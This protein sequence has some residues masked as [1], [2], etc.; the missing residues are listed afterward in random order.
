M[1]TSAPAPPAEWK[2][3]LEHKLRRKLELHLVY[4]HFLLVLANAEEHSNAKGERGRA[5]R[6]W[7]EYLK[8]LIVIC[9]AQHVLDGFRREEK[10]RAG[11][12][13]ARRVPRY[14][15]S[16]SPLL[17]RFKLNWKL[18]SVLAAIE[19][20]FEANQRTQVPNSTCHYYH[21]VRIRPGGIPLPDGAGGLCVT[22]RS[23]R[24]SI[25]ASV[26]GDTGS[27]PA[28][29]ARR[30]ASSPSTSPPLNA[31]RTRRRTSRGPRP[32]LF[33]SA[34]LACARSPAQPFSSPSLSL[35]DEWALLVSFIF[36]AVPES[37][38]SSSS[39]AARLR[40]AFPSRKLLFSAF[41]SRRS[42]SRSPQPKPELPPPLA[43]V[44]IASFQAPSSRSELVVEFRAEVRKSPSLLSLSLSLS[45]AQPASPTP[46]MDDD[47]QGDPVWVCFSDDEDVSGPASP[48][49]DV[50]GNPDG[51]A[52][53]GDKVYEDEKDDEE[54]PKVEM[55]TSITE[56]GAFPLLLEDVLE[57]LG[58][59]TRPL[60]I[61]TYMTSISHQF[62][63]ELSRTEYC[64]LPRR[65]PGTEQTVVVGGG[66]TADP[67]LNVL[68]RVTAALNTDLEGVINEL[69]QA[70][71]RIA[72]LEEQLAEQQGQ[73][74]DDERMANAWSPPRK[75]LRYGAPFSVT[76]FRE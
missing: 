28:A 21:P 47:V 36:L 66:P 64:H 10:R 12:T 11:E 20:V 48:T 74:D 14:F 57:A 56:L 54:E 59:Y 37:N 23:A 53:E 25:A 9:R 19:N 38:S 75:K 73:G 7:I 45:R 3:G 67:R 35:A 68:A 62:Q 49:A 70:Q 13:T 52:D 26:A 31:R 5:A 18:I 2:D 50:E 76:Q 46:Q 58:N 30:Y 55:I 71:D 51:T 42:S 72:E 40:V 1:A 39:N 32:N 33:S 6:L 34:Q 65:R 61:T 43:R 44:A 24:S 4:L 16:Q 29:M 17:I 27:P 41:I 69:A 8:D 15:T 60:Y 63:E 22:D